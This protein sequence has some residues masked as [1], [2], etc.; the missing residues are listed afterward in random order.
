[1]G[2]HVQI[3]SEMSLQHRYGHYIKYYNSWIQSDFNRVL[4][5]K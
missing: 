1:M 2:G 3:L 5:A 4:F